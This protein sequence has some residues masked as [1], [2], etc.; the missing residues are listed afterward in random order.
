MF[1][2]EI[3]CHILVGINCGGKEFEILLTKS[4]KGDGGLK[5]VDVWWSCFFLLNGPIYEEYGS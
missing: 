3:V 1:C 5:I 2:L 4:D